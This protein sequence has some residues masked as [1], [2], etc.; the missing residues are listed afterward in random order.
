MANF[1]ITLNEENKNGC[2]KVKEELQWYGGN[3]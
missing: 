2:C 1:L 3:E